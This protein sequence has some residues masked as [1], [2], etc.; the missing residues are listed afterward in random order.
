MT[1]LGMIVGLLCLL[2]MVWILLYGY[3][4]TGGRIAFL[5]VVLYVVS[6][7]PEDLG[8]FHTVALIALNLM[9]VLLEMHYREKEN[10]K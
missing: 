8:V 3:R 7:V 9:A 6:P 4:T 2:A 1:A 10:N 5:F